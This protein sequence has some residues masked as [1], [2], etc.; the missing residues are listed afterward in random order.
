MPN[1]RGEIPKAAR[2][3]IQRELL[4][5]AGKRIRIIIEK[6]TKKRSNEQ[7]AYYFGVIVKMISQ[8]TGY[9]DKEVHRL[10]AESFLGTKEVKIGDL[11]SKQPISTTTCSTSDFM[12]YMADIQQWAA[13]NINLYLPDP[14]EVVNDYK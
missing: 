5:Y 14:N 3:A 4:A 6:Y 11:V 7:N 12:A 10:L 2:Q 1:A 13:E 8:H 9:T